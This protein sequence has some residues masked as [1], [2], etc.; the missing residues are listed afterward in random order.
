MSLNTPIFSVI[1]EDT[2]RVAKAAFPKGN[3][4]LLLRDALGPLF[5]SIDFQHLFS[6]DGRPA[7]APAR[8]ALITVL[9]FAERLSDDQAANA[10]RSRIDWKYLLALPLDDAGFD[11]SVLS[12]FRTRLIQGNA[13][14]LLF[15]TLLTTSREYG[16]LRA[17]GRQR[18]DSTHVLAAVRALNRLECVGATL[19]HALNSLAVVVPQWLLAHSDPDWV[20]RYGPR[21]LDDR[22]PESQAD[23]EGLATIIGADGQALLTAIDADDT[24]AWLCNVPAV[25]TL[26]QVWIQNYT[27]ARHGTLRWRTS[28][29]IPPAR[30]FIG[31]PYDLDARYSQKRTTSW[32]GYNV[33]LSESCDADLP[34]LITNVETTLATTAADAVTPTIHAALE[35]R[36]LL[37]TVHLVDTGC[38]D[39][40]LL[41][42]SERQYEVDLLGPARGDYHR[43]AREGQGFAAQNFTIDWEAQQATCP[44]GRTSLSWTP[45]VDKRTNQVIK[46]KFSMRDCQPCI[47]RRHCTDAKRR[48]I[49]VRPKEQDLALRANRV[50]QVTAEFRAA[51]AKRA[52]VE[53][54]ISQGVRVTGLRRARYVGLA[55]TRLQHLAT[56]AAINLLRV[57]DWLDERPRA[58]TRQSRFERL[59][60]MAA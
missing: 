41:V 16:L 22:L 21:F 42:E 38:I 31:S 40:E 11:A 47:H 51:Y 9:Q 29:E 10:V 17:R 32:V 60:R 3:H 28:D 55:K 12:E 19:R 33:H 14:H 57:S 23:R 53:G 8:L 58:T 45:A 49:T 56:A 25:Q 37:P 43:Q 30:Q 48:T 36:D 6:T 13:E 50:R 2:T 7:E 35:Q 44:A 24:P 27:W 5:T 46:I 26:R 54:T 1:P 18:S 4:Y 52:G 59:Y 20:Q 39:A 15:E 34:H